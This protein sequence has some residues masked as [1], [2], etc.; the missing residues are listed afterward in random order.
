MRNGKITREEAV[1]LVNKYDQEFPAKH[2]KDFLN[3]IDISEDEFYS[4]IDKFRPAHLWHKVDN[5]WQ[6]RHVVS[7]LSDKD[8]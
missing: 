3:Y 6:L 2:F 7:Q 1:Y 5:Q 4:T 8:G